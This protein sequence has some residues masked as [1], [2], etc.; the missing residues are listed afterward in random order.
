[1]YR[2]RQVARMAVVPRSQMGGSVRVGAGRLRGRRCRR[3]W[4]RSSGGR[5]RSW[6]GGGGVRGDVFSGMGS[7]G[8]GGGDLVF[9][10]GEC[11]SMRWS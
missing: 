11:S 6:L 2:R 3:I 9:E 10:G 7:L 4:A 5:A 1:M 8:D